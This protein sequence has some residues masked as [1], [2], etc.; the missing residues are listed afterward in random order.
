MGR[1]WSLQGKNA[2]L[3]EVLFLDFCRLNFFVDSNS[4]AATWDCISVLV[5][6][7]YIITQGA[8]YYVVSSFVGT[9]WRVV[10]WL[11]KTREWNKI[12]LFLCPNK[13][14]LW[15]SP[16]VYYASSELILSDTRNMSS[17]E[18]LVKF[19]LANVFLTGKSLAGKSSNTKKGRE[20]FNRFTLSF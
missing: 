19:I 12:K 10:G 3:I 15:T 7:I 13:I 9:T 16:R 2:W 6:G 14:K 5:I 11:M 8:L 1:N 18:R 20:L 17:C 4:L